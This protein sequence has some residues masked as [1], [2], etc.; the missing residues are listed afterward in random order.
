MKKLINKFDR[1]Q[2]PYVSGKVLESCGQCG[3]VDR[4]TG[5]YI[6][7]TI[8]P[9]EFKDKRLTYSLIGFTDII[10]PGEKIVLYGKNADEIV[11]IQLPGKNASILLETAKTDY[12]WID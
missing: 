7:I 11:A 8:K 4:N 1:V 6:N 5:D 12:K 10:S 2:L 3:R 9:N